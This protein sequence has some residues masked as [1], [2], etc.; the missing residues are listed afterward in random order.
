MRAHRFFISLLIVQVIV[1]CMTNN[2]YSTVSASPST[3][4]CISVFINTVQVSSKFNIFDERYNIE[5]LNVLRRFRDSDDQSFVM[6]MSGGEGQ[7]FL[8]RKEPFLALKRFFKQS[9][10]NRR[11]VELLKDAEAQV[12]RSPDLSRVLEIARI[13]DEGSDWILRDYDSNS[14]PL[15]K[16]LNV[17]YIYNM[18]KNII[19]ILSGTN[20]PS[21]LQIKKSLERNPPS[22]NIHWSPTKNKIFIFDLTQNNTFGLSLLSA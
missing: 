15:G 4:S 2:A 9:V 20:D 6:K 11:G 8:S 5:F 22:I 3:A 16:F 14:A 18:R 19:N 1:T 12:L 13:Y 17:P 10:N 21:L 7:I